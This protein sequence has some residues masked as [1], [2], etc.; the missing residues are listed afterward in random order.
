[1]RT[2]L[3]RNSARDHAPP[4]GMCVPSKKSPTPVTSSSPLACIRGATPADPPVREYRP[5]SSPGKAYLWAIGEEMIRFV[6]VNNENRQEGSQLP[7]WEEHARSVVPSQGLAT[8]LWFIL[9]LWLV[10]PRY[11]RGHQA[12][13]AAVALGAATA[14]QPRR[15]TVD[16][17]GVRRGLWS[18]RGYV[19]CLRR[20]PAGNSGLDRHHR[21]TIAS[22]QGTPSSGIWTI[23]LRSPGCRRVRDGADMNWQRRAWLEAGSLRV[24]RGRAVGPVAR[25]AGTGSR[26]LPDRPRRR[27]GSD[28]PAGPRSLLSAGRG[29][30]R[31][32]PPPPPAG[33]PAP[34]QGPAWASRPPGSPRLR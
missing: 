25:S 12:G 13:P 17:N 3:R 34:I 31:S 21:A 9:F 27:S 14:A 10:P 11:R 1:M 8:P 30:A 5:Q 33:R 15:G 29:R 19:H 7:T 32:Y 24:E 2:R 28:A 6:A 18:G 4:S 26:P 23:L 20:D 16:G 22:L